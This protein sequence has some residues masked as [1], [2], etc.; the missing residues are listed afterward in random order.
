MAPDTIPTSAPPIDGA[1]LY[2]IALE[3]MLESGYLS[4]SNA[5]GEIIA[6]TM[7]KALALVFTDYYTATLTAATLSHRAHVE[8]L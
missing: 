7:T 5:V 3:G 4:A 8:E 6:Y 2:V 1:P